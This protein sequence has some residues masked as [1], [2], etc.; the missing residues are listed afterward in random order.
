LLLTGIETLFLRRPNY[1][2]A[3]MLTELFR[4]SHAMK[5]FFKRELISQLFKKS[6]KFQNLEFRNPSN[7]IYRQP[8]E[9]SILLTS[10]STC[11][12][13]MSISS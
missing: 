5:S 11:F 7:S 13:S 10:K 8:I 6:L 3:T 4:L 1:N 2:P 12:R 9:Y